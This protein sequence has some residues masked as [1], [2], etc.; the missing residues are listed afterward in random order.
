MSQVVA[1]MVLVI[2]AA[3]SA[4]VQLAMGTGS[5]VVDHAVL[6]AHRHQ[7]TPYGRGGLSVL[8]YR[9]AIVLRD[10]K[11]CADSSRMVSR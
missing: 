9:H 1:H 10:D 6:K 4:T 8:N 5:G 7:W 2:I 11:R 3:L